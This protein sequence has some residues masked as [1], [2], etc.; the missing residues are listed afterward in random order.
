VVRL[1]PWG[2]GDR[3]LLERLLA[4]PAMMEHLGGPETLEKI[5]E[6][7]GRYE[8]P[9]SNQFKIVYSGEGVGWVG[10]WEM[11]WGGETVYEMGWSVVPE[12][13]GR[14]IAGQATVLALEAARADARCQFVHASPSIDNGPSNAICRK[15]GFELRG[16]VETEYPPGHP[17]IVSDWWFDI[18][19]ARPAPPSVP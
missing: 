19:P 17:L 5:A 18:R 12:F 16:E 10:F 15:A 4:D 9:G 2:T 6:R 13:Q 11:E 1:E 7:Q 3:P 8:Q 14:G